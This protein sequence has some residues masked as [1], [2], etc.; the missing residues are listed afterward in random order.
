MLGSHSPVDSHVVDQKRSDYLSASVRHK[1]SQFQFQHVRVYYRVTSGSVSPVVEH[2]NRLRPLSTFL[3]LLSP[4]QMEDF[5]SLLQCVEFVE[6]TGS[7]LEYHMGCTF[8]YTFSFFVQ[9]NLFTNVSGTQAS[10]GQPWR[11]FCRIVSSQ[12]S[13]TRFFISF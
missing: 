9:S 12:H 5:R 4:V 6:I 8:V 1:S 3:L 11:E 10:E 13:I 2:L 7:Q